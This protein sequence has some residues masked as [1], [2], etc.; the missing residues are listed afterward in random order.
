MHVAVGVQRKD[1]ES[2]KMPGWRTWLLLVSLGLSA[3]IDSAGLTSQLIVSQCGSDWSVVLTPQYWALHLQA[4]PLTNLVM[5]LMS[6]C[7][8]GGAGRMNDRSASRT[9]AL[10]QMAIV[11]ALA[12]VL[13]STA[14]RLFPWLADPRLYALVM[15]RTYTG[16]ELVPRCLWR[17]CQ[18]PRG[19]SAGRAFPKVV[20]PKGGADVS[21]QLLERPR[22]MHGRAGAAAGVHLGNAGAVG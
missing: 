8:D 21:S 22:T 16:F 2:R 18:C 15:V 17:A 4:F 19:T 1:A 12:C 13:A 3:T 9:V 11:M 10:A 5:V 7:P 6:L 14:V 20:G